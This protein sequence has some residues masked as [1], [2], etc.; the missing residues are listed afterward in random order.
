MG[1]ISTI[2][3]GAKIG[4]QNG[5]EILGR[6]IDG[7]GNRKGSYGSFDR[8]GKGEM[9]GDHNRSVLSDQTFNVEI[10]LFD[11]DD[12]ISGERWQ[13]ENFE[14]G[15]DVFGYD[16][17]GNLTFGFGGDGYTAGVNTEGSL[18][19]FQ[20]DGALFNEYG[21]IEGGA[22]Y[23]LWGETETEFRYNP[24]TGSGGVDV[25]GGLFAGSEFNIGASTLSENGSI[26]LIGRRGLFIDGGMDLDIDPANRSGGLEFE[27]SLFSGWELDANASWSNRFLN[28]DVGV[29]GRFGPQFS[30]STAVNFN[31]GNW[32]FDSDVD[33]IGLWHINDANADI[34][35]NPEGFRELGSDIYNAADDWLTDMR[36]DPDFHPGAG[37][38]PLEDGWQLYESD[39]PNLDMS[40]QL[41]FDAN[42]IDFDT[43]D[44]FDFEADTFDVNNID[45]DISGG[46]DPIGNNWST[47]DTGIAFDPGS[48]DV[49]SF[50][51]GNI[52]VGAF[53]MG[54]IDVGAF[55]MGSFDVGS[56]DMG[57]FDMGSLD[58]GSFDMGS[59]DMGGF[60]FTTLDLGGVDIA[61]PLP[62]IGG[63]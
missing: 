44:L 60:I 36:Y 31:N 3:A 61:N 9:I 8:R 20:A 4:V 25:E 48:I 17:N 23:G 30:G 59:L 28:M 46:Y 6:S 40:D 45:L 10:P 29:D 35:L 47:Y 2:L 11:V 43:S 27:G 62:G 39:G 33:R 26:D 37:Y 22:S 55:D 41:I 1:Q 32:N 15:T 49:G 12:S 19:L 51:V 52:D 56:F 58:M 24:A 16:A 50:D 21:R 34:S 38:A 57:S 42:N 7:N 13:T 5:K 53:D 18:N 14:Y 54:S 63:P